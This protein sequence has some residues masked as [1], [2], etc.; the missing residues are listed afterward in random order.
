MKKLIPAIVLLL[1]SAVVMSTASYAWFSMN[2]KVSVTGMEIKTKVSSNLLIAA[3]TLDS[4]GKKNDSLFA[5]ELNQ[6]VK[7]FVEPVSTADAKT[8]FYTIDAK[9]DGSKNHDVNSSG[10]AFV[11]Y[12]ASAAASGATADNFGDLFSQTYGVTK[13]D[14]TAFTGDVNKAVPYVDYVFQLKATNTETSP[15]NIAVTKIQLQYKGSEDN[16]QKAY[17]VAFF[18]EDITTGTATAAPVGSAAILPIS[19]AA[20]FDGKV[21]NGTTS[22]VD[23]NYATDGV[24]ASV[25]N[26]AI[27]YYKVVV[28]LW[29]EGQDTTC[30]TGTFMALNSEWELGVELQLTSGT[31]V[32]SIKKIDSNATLLG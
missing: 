19:S 16:V 17:R 18:V 21:V 15:R 12:N 20:N 1:I 5:S 31:G 23:A 22:Y 28:R 24:L 11:Q 3:D 13:S 10:Y 27:K 7:G 4:T 14:A 30:N 32:N 29:L 26:G 8:F 9:A 25:D 6:V 2:N